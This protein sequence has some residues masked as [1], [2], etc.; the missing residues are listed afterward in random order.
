MFKKILLPL[1]LT[2]KHKVVLQ[3]AAELAQ[4]GG[5]EVTLLHVI[6]IIPSLSLEEGRDFYGRLERSARSHLERLSRRLKKRKVPC[7]IEIL[8]GN[9]AG[10]IALY[11]EEKR[12][13]LLLLTSP[14]INPKQPGVGWG[15]LSFKVAI[16][17]RC[18]VL[19][20]K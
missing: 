14:I 8:Y 17:A 4:Q 1:D 2:D 5:D 19:L 20:V 10:Q 18:P 7:R 9:R 3:A 15:S 11:A 6:E 16:L 12:F 13:D